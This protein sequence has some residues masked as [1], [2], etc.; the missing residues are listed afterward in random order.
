MDTNSFFNKVRPQFFKKIWG[1]EFFSSHVGEV[2]SL[3]ALHPFV[4]IFEDSNIALP[5]NLP[6]LIKWID[7]SDFLSVQVHP[8]DEQAKILEGQRGKDECWLICQA[9][10][11][12]GVYL[13]FKDEE[14]ISA[15]KIRSC[16]EAGQGLEKFLQFFPVK[17][18]DFF[19]V[20]ATTVHAIGKGV[21]LL[22]IQQ[23]SGIT[24]RFWDWNRV[25]DKGVAREVHWEKAFQVANWGAY[26]ETLENILSPHLY[27]PQLLLSHQDFSVQVYVL[28]VGDKIL[29][30]VKQNLPEALVCF[31]GEMDL[32]FSTHS[33]N[34]KQF[35]TIYLGKDR[36]TD[37]ASIFIQAKQQSVLVVVSATFWV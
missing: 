9:E 6:F 3:S 13:G 34:L 35:E 37:H 19:Y 1:G 4:S 32:S 11:G 26:K 36:E 24:Y 15:E 17:K 21:T 10:E 33:C 20:P 25:D 29:Y 28:A 30:D 23:T 12:A 31:S 2:W 22:E 14:G 16:L 5:S 18:G 7:T 8:N 27:S